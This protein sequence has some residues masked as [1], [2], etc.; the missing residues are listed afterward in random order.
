MVIGPSAGHQSFSPTSWLESRFEGN[1]MG[2]GCSANMRER[3]FAV[4]PWGQ[5]WLIMCFVRLLS[6]KRCAHNRHR[7]A[8]MLYH[9]SPGID[10]LAVATCSLDVCAWVARGRHQRRPRNPAPRGGIETRG[11]GP[12][13]EPG[14]P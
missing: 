2:V 8:S 1:T 5:Q 6:G 9:V 12:G 10:V 13:A 4:L 3:V 7:Y 14:H 11:W